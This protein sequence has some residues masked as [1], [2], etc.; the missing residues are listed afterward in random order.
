MQIDSVENKRRREKLKNEKVFFSFHL[1]SATMTAKRAKMPIGGDRLVMRDDT[2][3]YLQRSTSTSLADAVKTQNVF[4]FFTVESVAATAAALLPLFSKKTATVAPL[5]TAINMRAALKGSSASTPDADQVIVLGGDSVERLADDELVVVVSFELAPTTDALLAQSVRA[6]GSLVTNISRYGF[7]NPKAFTD[8]EYV[9]TAKFEVDEEASRQCTALAGERSLPRLL[10]SRLNG[11]FPVMAH[12][13]VLERASFLAAMMPSSA[14]SASGRA[15]A[16]QPDQQPVPLAVA[17][18]STVQKRVDYR[19]AW[20]ETVLRQRA[21]TVTAIVTGPCTKSALLRLS[22]ATAVP[23][24]AAA[25][26]VDMALWQAHCVGA[27]Q[28]PAALSYL[29]T[30]RRLLALTKNDVAVAAPPP[31]EQQPSPLAQTLLATSSF[32]VLGE[33]SASIS[34]KASTAASVEVPDVGAASSDRD[35]VVQIFEPLR[36]FA[37]NI[38]AGQL[39]VYEIKTYARARL[40]WHIMRASAYKSCTAESDTED[41]PRKSGAH[42]GV[43]RQIGRAVMEREAHHEAIGIGILALIASPHDDLRDSL[44]YLEALSIEADYARHENGDSDRKAAALQSRLDLLQRFWDVCGDVE[45][46]SN[47]PTHRVM[48]AIASDWRQ[49]LARYR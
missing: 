12:L 33:S 31:Q 6:M 14:D 32:I 21:Y 19:A 9:G 24:D 26:V 44:L 4:G 23:F 8:R 35:T 30:R 1:V 7:A 34:L 36:Y 39:T 2:Q 16:V 27:V 18:K 46:A 17:P 13:R 45:Y 28:P 10:Y 42:R 43:L 41:Y 22:T 5:K 3:L 20:L 15:G 48:S 11:K 40:H 38:D 25:D 29:L 37:H 47:S 49:S